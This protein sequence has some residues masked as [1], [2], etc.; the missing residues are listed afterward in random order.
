MNPENHNVK[1]NFKR[2]CLNQVH[3]NKILIYFT[4]VNK[5]SCNYCKMDESIQGGWP[6]NENINN[7]IKT[8]HIKKVTKI[9]FS[10]TY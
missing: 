8:T 2:V 5:T 4:K 1:K 10:L 6:E 3:L 9:H 7:G